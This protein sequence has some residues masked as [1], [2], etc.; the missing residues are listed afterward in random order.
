MMMVIV[1]ICDVNS[2]I[3]MMRM[4]VVVKAV[5]IMIAVIMMVRDGGDESNGTERF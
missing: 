1:M 4:M 5:E 2:N 3:K